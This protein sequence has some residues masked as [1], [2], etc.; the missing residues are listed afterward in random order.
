MRHACATGGPRSADGGGV[1][2]GGGG[3]GASPAVRH[4]VAA[5][6]TTATDTTTIGRV[7][8]FDGQRL[9]GAIG[10]ARVE[11]EVGAYLGGGGAGVVYEATQG[12]V[13]YALKMPTPVAYK[14]LPPAVVG[15]CTVLLKGAPLAPGSSLRQEHLWYLLE[16]ASR[17]LVVA[18]EDPRVARQ[19]GCAGGLGLAGLRELPLHAAE[20]LWG[21][22]PP[23]LLHAGEAAPPEWRAVAYRGRSVKLPRVPGKYLRL[24]HARHA[25]CREA[26][27]MGAAGRHR[28]VLRLHAALEQF[29]ESKWA[30]FLLLELATGGE[31]FDFIK[32]REGGDSGGG[33]G[34]WAAHDAG[35]W[36]PPQAPCL[37]GGGHEE[38]AV[39][40][41]DTGVGDAVGGGRGA[42]AAG[43]DEEQEQRQEGHEEAEAAEAQAQDED[44]EE[45]AA[46]EAELGPG[47]RRWSQQA[48]AAEYARQLLEG[49]AH[50]HARGVA[51]RDLKPENLLLSAAA[52]PGTAKLRQRSAE[53]VAAAAG[54]APLEAGGSWA[55][56]SS[57]GSS[58]DSDEGVGGHDQ[59]PS[60][61]QQ[62]QQQQQQRLPAA[63]M[64]RGAQR[65][66]QVQQQQQQQQ[67]E[68]AHRAARTSEGRRAHHCG[69]PR[70][71]R[72][73]ALPTLKIC[74]FGLAAV[75]T[76]A[77]VEEEV[78]APPPAAAGA[79]E[80]GAPEQQRR[81]AGVGCRRRRRRALA[82]RC[83][84][85]L[86]RHGVG[87]RRGGERAARLG[88][89]C[90]VVALHGGGRR[91]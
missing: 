4:A 54:L 16:P 78:V 85:A 53:T 89:V 30:L 36:P 48:I 58:A 46:A 5:T 63:R 23:E 52:P 44:E 56:V 81:R 82:P 1:V 7:D 2:S 35:W 32:R 67:Q 70:R 88:G 22:Q 15:R 45:E 90:R 24:L 64:R 10:D 40:V 18:W 68:P 65:Q 14:L 86:P 79:G 3:G 51:H 62:R 84:A 17:A 33:C 49:V 6:N 42:D 8:T 20:E 83:P 61:R 50:L 21:S 26:R 87:W 77:G 91:P 13:A 55:S 69:H 11:L 12:G 71:R 28:H 39:G 29:S 31:L 34:G 80:G 60:Q 37:G 76:P 27:A 43:S 72:L 25:A 74:D 57:G 66:Q 38:A 73:P 59:W 47:V 75:D 41:D 9:R 19:Y